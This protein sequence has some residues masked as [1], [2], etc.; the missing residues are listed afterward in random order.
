M[1]SKKATKIDGIFTVDLMLCNVCFIKICS[2]FSSVLL[3]IVFTTNFYE[4]DVSKR[5]INGEDFVNFCGLFR[6]YE[7]Y[8]SFSI[9]LQ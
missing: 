4:T 8:K 9:L 6:K 5:Q 3:C 1:L 7:L 2:K